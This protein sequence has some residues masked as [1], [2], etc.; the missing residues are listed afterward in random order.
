MIKKLINWLTCGHMY[1]HT[2]HNVD[3]LVAQW[4][5]HKGICPYMLDA[6]RSLSVARDM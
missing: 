2:G 3:P 1:V 4:C 6:T 5:W